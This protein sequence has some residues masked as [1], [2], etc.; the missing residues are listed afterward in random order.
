MV[1]TGSWIFETIAQRVEMLLLPVHDHAS[2]KGRIRSQGRMLKAKVFKQG[3][4]FVIR[5]HHRRRNGLVHVPV[6][7]S[8]ENESRRD[9]HRDPGKREEHLFGAVASGCDNFRKA[10]RKLNQRRRAA[11]DM[12]L[13]A[14]RTKCMRQMAIW[15]QSASV[16]HTAPLPSHLSLPTYKLEV[17]QVMSPL[18][19]ALDAFN[20]LLILMSSIDRY[21]Q[22]C[23]HETAK[24]SEG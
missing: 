11:I 3:F 15:K 18:P 24:G 19:Q 13:P 2:V 5:L 4:F 7:G 23:R 20:S 12:H 6:V 10:R 16:T 22:Y 9:N 1:H 14:P 21:Y 17:K 8:Q